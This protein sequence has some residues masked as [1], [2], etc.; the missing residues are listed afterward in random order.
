MVR[1]DDCLQQVVHLLR[2]DGLVSL[3][4]LNVLPAFRA[5]IRI[6]AGNKVSDVFPMGRFEVVNKDPFLHHEVEDSPLKQFGLIS[7]PPSFL[8]W[9]G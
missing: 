1:F 7:G 8:V 3:L 2:P 9:L 6:P 4:L 5:H